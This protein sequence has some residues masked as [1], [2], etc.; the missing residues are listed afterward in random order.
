MEDPSL[1]ACAVE[2]PDGNSGGILNEVGI[3]NN[4]ATGIDDDAATAPR[5]LHQSLRIFIQ[6]KNR[7]SAKN[8]RF[9]SRRTNCVDALNAD[10]RF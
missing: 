4:N 9:I 5:G 8:T 1:E 2:K 6:K 7:G 10:K 3:C